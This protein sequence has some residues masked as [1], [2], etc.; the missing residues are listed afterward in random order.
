MHSL[1]KLLQQRYSTNR[2]EGRQRFCLF[3]KAFAALIWEMW[4]TIDKKGK[5]TLFGKSKLKKS[6]SEES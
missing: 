5:K 3:M 4:H 1:L 6:M 2:S